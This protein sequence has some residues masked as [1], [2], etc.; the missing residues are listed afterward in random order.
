MTTIKFR[1]TN[2]T[3]AAC[4]KLSTMALEKI[5]DVTKAIVDLETGS[6]ELSANRTVAWNEITDALR[7]VG[8][9][10]HSLP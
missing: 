8:K 5:A 2:I 7:S 3:C 1:I 6:V 4:V 10:A 9:E